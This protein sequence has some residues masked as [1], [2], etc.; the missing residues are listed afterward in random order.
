MTRYVALLRGVNVGGKHLVPMPRLRALAAE[1]GFEEPATHLQSGNLLLS[2]SASAT[3]V[4]QTLGAAIEAEFGFACPVLVRSRDQLAAIVAADVL[5]DVADDDAKRLVS[6]LSAKP[7]AASVRALDPEA[8][9][10]ERF[11]VVGQELYLWCPDGL[12]RSRLAVAPW[13]RMLGGVIPTS[14]NWRTV[15][16]LLTMLS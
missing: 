15:S 1:V 8:Y 6:F 5:G 3:T 16:K 4:E 12:A 13:Q 11:A 10:P 9:L 2:A 7:P 14:R